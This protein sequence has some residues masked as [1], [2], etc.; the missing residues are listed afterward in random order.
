MSAPPSSDPDSAGVNTRDRLVALAQALELLL[1]LA[2]DA[3]HAVPLDDRTTL[4]GLGRMR[5]QFSRQQFWLLDRAKRGT[6]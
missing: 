4:E 1:M 3:E 2:V 6:P 5:L